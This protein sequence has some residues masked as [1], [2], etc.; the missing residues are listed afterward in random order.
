MQESKQ[1]QQ[2]MVKL[3]LRLPE[4]SH[5]S[6]SLQKHATAAAASL[7]GSLLCDCTPGQ[8]VEVCLQNPFA[9]DHTGPKPMK[10]TEPLRLRIGWQRPR[11]EDIVSCS[12]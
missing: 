4:T 8:T 9:T 1:L 7:V 10:R 5:F 12:C 6:C 11:H 3:L 2:M